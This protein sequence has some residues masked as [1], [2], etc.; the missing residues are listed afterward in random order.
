MKNG[1]VRAAVSWSLILFYVLVLQSLGFAYKLTRLSTDF[2][3]FYWGAWVAF[4]EHRSPYTATAFDGAEVAIKQRVFPYLYPPPSLLGFYPF[5][6]LPYSK[7]RGIMVAVN[8]A[9]VLY[10]LYLFLVKTVGFSLRQLATEWLPIGIVIYVLMNQG[11]IRT[12]DHGQINLIVLVLV[13][14]T[15]YA[16]KRGAGAVAV[17]LPLA[18]AIGFKTY[19]ILLLP[20]LIFR[21]RY[22]AAAAVLGFLALFTAVAYGVLPREVWGD[23]V[24]NVLPTGGYGKVPFNLFSP[25][26]GSNQSINGFTSR[27]F[28]PNEFYPV[29]FPSPRMAAL[30]ATL[31]SGIVVL[32]TLGFC[33]WSA[34]RQPDFAPRPGGVGPAH[35]IE[36]IDVEWSLGLAMTF[37]VAPL[38]WH[39]HLVF[40][41]PTV[42]IAVLLL[43]DRAGRTTASLPV[44]G[45]WVLLAAALTVI[46]MPPEPAHYRRLWL[47]LNSR[48][49]YPVVIVWLFLL[50]SM[51]RN[52][53]GADARDA[54]V[55]SRDKNGEFAT[56]G[57]GGVASLSRLPLA[58]PRGA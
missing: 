17:A 26:A 47:L 56:T 6:L 31:L 52:M 50:W 51:W 19:P 23:W 15:W 39:H 14:M 28:L 4:R 25:A 38:S 29:A 1:M 40:V 53:S 55:A 34:R 8:V 9:C 20:L 3:S 41:L 10:F 44:W 11:V 48:S 7:A 2:P 36:A 24:R 21:R 32:V 13:C 58:E 30:S 46:R 18:V 5:A 37:L 35:R 33:W 45:P 57:G 16:A 54:D 49:F 12:I 43:I 27:L 42:I 22:A